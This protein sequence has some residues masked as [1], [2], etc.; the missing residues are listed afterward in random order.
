VLVIVYLVP[1]FGGLAAPWWDPSATATGFSFGVTRAPLERASI[2]S[3][4]HQKTRLGTGRRARTRR[5]GRFA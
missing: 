5:I 2:D 1:A 4:A 3:I